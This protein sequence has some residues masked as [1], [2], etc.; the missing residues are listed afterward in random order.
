MTFDPNKYLKG[1]GESGDTPK[2]DGGFDASKYLKKKEPTESASTLEGGDSSLGLQDISFENL[3]TDEVAGGLE[4]ARLEYYRLGPDLYDI[5]QNLKS[6]EGKGEKDASGRLLFSNESDLQQYRSLVE[7]YNKLLESQNAIIAREKAFSEELSKRLEGQ[8]VEEQPEQQPD[9]QP[10]QTQK[11]NPRTNYL[12]RRVLDVASGALGGLS[13]TLRGINDVGSYLDRLSGVGEEKIEEHREGLDNLANSI[14]RF[15]E[16]YL[17]TQGVAE[18]TKAEKYGRLLGQGAGNMATFMVGGIPAA[19]SKVGAV[20][21][22]STIGAFM[23]AGAQAKE[24]KDKIADADNLTAGQ[25]AE[26]YNIPIEEAEAAQRDLAEVDYRD[27]EGSVLGTGLAVGLG[28]GVVGTL[29]KPIAGF[30]TKLNVKTGG[31]FS[32]TLKTL[33]DTRGGIAVKDAIVEGVQEGTAQWLNNV[34]AKQIYDETRSLMDGVPEEA[35]LGGIL[36]PSAGLILQRAKDIERN[37]NSTEQERAEAE[38]AK[39]YLANKTRLASLQAEGGNTFISPEYLGLQERKKKLQGDLEGAE[40]SVSASLIE[41]ETA[42]IEGQMQDILASSNGLFSTFDKDDAL[43]FEEI[44][45]RLGELEAISNDPGIS[46]SVKARYKD[47]A[48]S[49]LEERNEI[50]NKYTTQKEGDSVTET[51]E[52]DAIQEPETEEVD[53]RE[54]TEVSEE[55]GAEVQVQEEEAEAPPSKERVDA[56]VE[57]VVE[58]LK[59]GELGDNTNPNVLLENAISYLQ[60]FK[61]YQEASDVE[62]DQAVRKINERLGIKIKNPPSVNKILGLKKSTP[63]KEFTAKQLLTLA[64][65]DSRRGAKEGARKERLKVEDYAK[66]IKEALKKVPKGFLNTTQASVLTKASA[67]VATPYQLKR[68]E[69]VAERILSNAEYAKKLIDSYKKRSKVKNPP[70]NAPSNIKRAFRDFLKINPSRVSNLEEYNRVANGLIAYKGKP[71]IKVSEGGVEITE[72]LP[73]NVESINEFIDNFN[74]QNEKTI[75]EDLISEN[76]ELVELGIIDE[77]LSLNEIN[78]ILDSIND[79][80]SGESVF[81]KM[82]NGKRKKEAFAR[83]ISAIQDDL[84]DVSSRNLSNQKKE[85]KRALENIDVDKLSPH[86]LAGLYAAIQNA[87]LNKAYN[88]A[89]KYVSIYKGQQNRRKGALLRESNARKVS[90]IDFNV[91]NI[92]S[93][94]RAL[95]GTSEASARLLELMGVSSIFNGNSHAET[96]T[97]NLTDKVDKL[98]GNGFNTIEEN[99]FLTMYA[100]LKTV[101][102][103]NFK[104]YKQHIE[105]AIKNDLKST[106]K[107]T[108]KNARVISKIFDKRIRGAKSINSIRISKKEQ[109]VI[110]L[111]ASEFR[112]KKNEFKELSEDV[113]NIEFEEVDFYLPLLFR[114]RKVTDKSLIGES[115]FYGD[116]VK[117]KKDGSLNKRTMAFDPNKMTFDFD[118]INATINKYSSQILDINTARAI[119]DYNY[120]MEPSDAVDSFGDEGTYNAV[121]NRIK[122][123]V[124]SRNDYQKLTPTQKFVVEFLNR[125][126]KYGMRVKLGS[127]LQIIVQ[128]IPVYARTA[129]IL[130]RDADLMG[131]AVTKW[132]SDSDSFNKLIE[133]YPINIRGFQKQE[134]KSVDKK[135]PRANKEKWKSRMRKAD[136]RLGDIA[137]TLTMLP[138]EIG[139]V[140]TAKATWFSFYLKSLKDQGLYEKGMSMKDIAENPNENAA[141]YAEQMVAETQ[142]PSDVNQQG[143]YFVP[144]DNVSNALR[145]VA[146]PFIT[147]RATQSYSIVNSLYGLK[148]KERK[149]AAKELAA[150]GVENVVFS[151]MSLLRYYFSLIGA[152]T[153]ASLFGVDLDEDED[154]KKKEKYTSWWMKALGES[155]AQFNP[156]YGYG[157]FD[158][159]QVDLLNKF[160]F[161]FIYSD[162]GKAKYINEKELKS[163]RSDEDIDIVM[164][165]AFRNFSRS[166]DVPLRDWGASGNEKFYDRLGQMGF[167][168]GVIDQSKEA[169][170]MSQEEDV[171]KYVSKWNSTVE[172]EFSDSEKDVLLMSAILQISNFFLPKEVADVGRRLKSGVQYKNKGNKGKKGNK[173]SPPATVTPSSGTPIR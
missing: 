115:F 101:G 95:T 123:Y 108:A 127:A 116:R 90:E 141:S 149:T 100:T 50:E 87:M 109:D 14:D 121:K 10:I 173:A 69:E 11:F 65:I 153:L 13:L 29:G 150:V 36:G 80:P 5:E 70:A 66:K 77:T 51:Q 154:E 166:N 104:T 170:E 40:N 43:R 86:H 161:Y 33:A 139:D 157:V 55:V 112:S 137:D 146:F 64:E 9:Q 25:F 3:S 147:F 133:K 92:R 98:I 84:K 103:E 168:F 145:K 102:R 111:L 110:D 52:A 85:I 164:D 23:N 152:R 138:I 1:K 42:D 57:N 82:Q 93:V 24:A 107:D 48:A 68:F 17:Q 136:Q 53:V 46:E 56:I 28:E 117:Q 41:R 144:K 148:G 96:E 27:I 54:Q 158:K 132:A 119:S 45:I 124:E 129:T 19:G 32:K 131:E 59:K 126:A 30:L 62:R 91:G 160:Y 162:E 83:V 89:Y 94:F 128:T 38:R 159:G 106:D 140:S 143:N 122:R 6:F 81:D 105:D 113:Y 44:S 78:E 34:S 163:A 63:K 97:Q 39:R 67:G 49:L 18:D 73:L 60:G 120:Y 79:E 134:F 74:K 167:A 130:G 88:G 7:D 61:L 12:Q 16:V 142:T 71:S 35:L 156:L 75:K 22:G 171:Y 47:E 20:L 26:K 169:F 4:K 76:E 172:K 125:L 15:S 118:F 21:S 99:A 155:V 114:K 72:K 31:N 58:K 151:G 135:I 2:Q 165:K 8:P 37:P